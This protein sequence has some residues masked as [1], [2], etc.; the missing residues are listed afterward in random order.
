MIGSA[1]LS[2]I[3]SAMVLFGAALAV[4]AG[5][6]LLTLR[7]AYAR[8]HAAG[9]SSPVAF[10]LVAIGAG[11]VLGAGASAQLA[12]AVLALMITMPVGIHLLFRAVHRTGTEPLAHDALRGVERLPD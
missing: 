10:V 7:T 8:I 5:V 3:A 2:A 11:L 6:G 12:V 9:K 1:V 4:L